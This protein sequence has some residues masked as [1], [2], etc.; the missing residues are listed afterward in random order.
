MIEQ[1]AGR[2]AHMQS[3]IWVIAHQAGQHFLMRLLGVGSWP[4]AASPTC[5]TDALPPKDLQTQQLA[6][7]A[8]TITCMLKI[9]QGVIDAVAVPVAECAGDDPSSADLAC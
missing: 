8:N 7:S 1:T 9:A 6:P 5:P 4:P 2:H 3:C